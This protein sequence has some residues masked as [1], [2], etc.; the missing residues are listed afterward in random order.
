MVIV[1][2]FFRISFILQHGRLGLLLVLQ[3]SWRGC[4]FETKLTYEKLRRLR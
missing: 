2:S 4:V 3:D 1:E